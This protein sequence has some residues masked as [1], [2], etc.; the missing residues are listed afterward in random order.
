MFFQGAMEDRMVESENESSTE[1]LEAEI[2][3]QGPAE[4][5]KESKKKTKQKQIQSS[6]PIRSGRFVQKCRAGPYR[7][8][9]DLIGSE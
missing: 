3:V 6:D 9:P 1:D 7:F 8:R 5:S 2:I 4:A